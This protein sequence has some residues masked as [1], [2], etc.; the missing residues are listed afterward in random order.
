VFAVSLSS[1]VADVKIG[2]ILCCREVWPD[3]EEFGSDSMA[4]EDE[5]LALRQ[6]CLTEFPRK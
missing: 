4:P 6:I 2:F 3:K 1:S 5:L